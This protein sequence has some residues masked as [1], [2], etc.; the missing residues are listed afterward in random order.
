MK[1]VE[2]SK[3]II[4]VVGIVLILQLVI[5]NVLMFVTQ[6]LSP[7][8][9]IIPSLDAVTGIAVG[10]YYWKAKAENKIKLMKENGIEPSEEVFEEI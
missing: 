10:F 9:Y 4:I 3:Y 8:A 2:F 7:L 5:A 6:D 1:K